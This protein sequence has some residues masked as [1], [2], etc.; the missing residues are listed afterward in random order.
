MT[1]VVQLWTQNGSTQTPEL[2]LGGDGGNFSTAHGYLSLAGARGRFD[3]NLFADQFHSDGQG[4]ND[5]YS[6]SLQ[7]E[8]WSCPE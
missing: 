4:I 7:V 1:G 6:N 8:I 2:R 5:E 3:Y